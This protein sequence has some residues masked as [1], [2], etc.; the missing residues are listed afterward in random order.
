MKMGK[1][2][3]WA[4]NS[5]RHA[6]RSIARAEKLL[7]FVDIK[8]GQSFLEVGC[9]NGATSKHIADKY[10]VNIT[11]VDVDPEQVQLAVENTGDIPNVRFSEADAT[12]LPFQDKEFDIILS[13]NV[14]HHI[15]KWLDTLKEVTRVLNTGGY[16]IYVDVV[17]PKW[18]ASIWSSRIGNLFVRSY[19][20]PTVHGLN[21]FMEQN[22]FSTVHSSL[23]NRLM[24]IF[25][26]YEAV[27]QRQ[28]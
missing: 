20:F 4:V 19:G 12:N 7:Q 15:P 3:K 25:N 21:S 27:Y 11:G 24:L 6:A 1:L 14:L 23:S 28:G 16:F 2:E 8:E 22:S 18:S 9:G 13:H 26:E 5:P 17:H 10:R